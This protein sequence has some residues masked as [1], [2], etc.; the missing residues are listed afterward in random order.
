MDLLG[1]RVQSV[2]Q[3]FGQQGRCPHQVAAPKELAAPNKKVVSTFHAQK[4]D[5]L[6]EYSV[7]GR[8]ARRIGI[9]TT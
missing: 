1:L 5:F 8:R 3:R 4:E 2:I 9:A 6:A 7:S